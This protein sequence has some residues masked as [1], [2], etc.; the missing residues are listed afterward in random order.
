MSGG[1]AF[2]TLMALGGTFLYG[3][4]ARKGAP[5]IRHADQCSFSMHVCICRLHFIQTETTTAS[6]TSMLLQWSLYDNVCSCLYRIIHCATPR[7]HDTY[8]A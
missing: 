5:G 8:P 1:L 6:S 7:R 2:G 3:N 4:Y